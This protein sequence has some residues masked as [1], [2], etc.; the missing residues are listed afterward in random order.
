MNNKS[1][2]DL[3]NRDFVFTRI[4]G[5]IMAAVRKVGAEEDLSDKKMVN[6]LLREALKARGVDIENEN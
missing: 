1:K 2:K 5:N 3:S 4:K 6:K